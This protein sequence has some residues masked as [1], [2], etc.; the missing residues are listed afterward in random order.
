MGKHKKIAGI[1][2][3]TNKVNGKK[4]IGY[5]E[6]ILKRWDNHKYLLRRDLGHCTHLQST[7]NIY[8]E[9]N[10]EFSI[11]EILPDNLTK[12]E[13]E[14]VETIW[15]LKFNTHLSEFGYNGV[16][17]GSIPLYKEEE[18][19]TII[20]RRNIPKTIYMCINRNIVGV[21][22]CD[23]PKEVNDLTG[24]PLNHIGEIASYWKNTD[25]HKTGK[26]S[27]VKKSKKGWIL[28]RKDMYDPAFDY[29]GHKKSRGFKD[30]VKKTWRDYYSKEKYRVSPENII[31][32]ED[33]NLKRVSV[34]AVN[35]ETGEE[36]KYNMIKACYN[37][38]NRTKV[39]K[40]LNAP[41]G[42]Y[43]HRGHYFRRT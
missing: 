35:I 5:S 38:F 29:I 9:K 43:K 32:H 13:Y 40:C 36:K 2:A 22:E 19:N 10:F 42:K 14:A 30:G 8:G 3:I 18:N 15:V 21:I 24:I 26:A 4:Y 17:P 20:N 34:V 41:F 25:V 33:R 28:V 31:P 7:W 12:Q 27:H 11:L 37:E 39:N 1:Y 16:L 6:S 23:G